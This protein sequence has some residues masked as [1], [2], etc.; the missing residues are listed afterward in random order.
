MTFGAVLMCF[1]SKRSGNSK[2]EYELSGAGVYSSLKSL[3]R[4]LAS[5]L[6]DV[7]M[8]LTI[9]L[10]AYSGLQQAFVW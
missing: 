2:E 8:L 6:S 7:R 1:L 9:P 4:S 5:A 3:S 10:I